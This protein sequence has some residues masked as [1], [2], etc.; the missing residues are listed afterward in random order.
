[1]AIAVYIAW[2]LGLCSSLLLLNQ[3]WASQLEKEAIYNVHYI[4]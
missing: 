2:W 3:L 4:F 1:M